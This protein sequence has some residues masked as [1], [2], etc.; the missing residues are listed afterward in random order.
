MEAL[1]MLMV[2]YDV[3]PNNKTLGRLFTIDSHLNQLNHN[4]IIS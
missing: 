4:I 2:D 1:T 3:L